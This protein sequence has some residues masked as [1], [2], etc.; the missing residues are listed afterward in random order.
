M[1]FFSFFVLYSSCCLFVFLF[2]FVYLSVSLFFL[3]VVFLK[4]NVYVGV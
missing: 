2:I 1:F 4:F 3:P